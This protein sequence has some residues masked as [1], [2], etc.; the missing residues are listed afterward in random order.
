MNFKQLKQTC[1]QSNTPILEVAQ[2]LSKIIIYKCEMYLWSFG[3]PKHSK[4]HWHLL[5]VMLQ[6]ITKCLHI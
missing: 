2:N 3:T 1:I 4:Y 5:S 6:H